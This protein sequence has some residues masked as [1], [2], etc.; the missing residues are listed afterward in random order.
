[1]TPTMPII[2]T[3]VPE[4]KL[5]YILLYGR[6]AMSELVI[7]EKAL[8]DDPLRQPNMKIMADLLSVDMDVDLDSLKKI[9]AR[10]RSLHESGWIMEQTAI[11]TNNRMLE[12]LGDAYELMSVGVPVQFKIFSR[13]ADAISWLELGESQER[14]K[15][16]HKELI[17]RIS[18]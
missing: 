17:D 8:I 15:T 3:I 7:Y 14:I 1:M 18:S 13:L 9:I 16:L 12:L 10:H 2:H 4:H 5:L 11:L 6:V